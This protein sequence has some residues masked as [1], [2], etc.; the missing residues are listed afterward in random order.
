MGPTSKRKRRNGR[1]RQREG[2]G[3]DKGRGLPPLYLT[4]ACGPVTV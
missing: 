3:M 4:T 2:K 1:R